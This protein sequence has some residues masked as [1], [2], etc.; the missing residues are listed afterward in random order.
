MKLKRFILVAIF[1][2]CA[3]GQGYSQTAEVKIN[4]LAGAVTIFNP[5][6]EIGVGSHSSLTFDYVGCFA[7]EDFMNTDQQ[8]LLSMGLFGYRYYFKADDH[9]GFFVGGDAGLDVFRMTKNIVPLVANDK[10]DSYDVGFGYLFGVTLG[11]KYNFT[12]RWAIEGS[13]SGG[14]QHSWHEGYTADGI[15][16]V[17]FNKSG[18]WLPYKAGIYISYKLW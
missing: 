17:E 8:L 18:E 3:L 6:F 14:W 16:Y 11:Y 7:K 13:V 5:S 15:R 4:A 9:N 12:E 2:I 1:V 10:G